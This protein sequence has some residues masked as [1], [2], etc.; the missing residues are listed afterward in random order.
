[1]AINIQISD[2]QW[3][4]LNKRKKRGETFQDVFDRIIS[5]IKKLKLNEELK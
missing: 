1:M 2:S 3:N 4:F 5:M